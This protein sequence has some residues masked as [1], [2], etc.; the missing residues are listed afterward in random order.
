MHRNICIAFV[1]LYSGFWIFETYFCR[2]SFSDRY[3]V[4]LQRGALPISTHGVR[5][6]SRSRRNFARIPVFSATGRLHEPAHGPGKLLL[7]RRRREG[8]VRHDR[9]R[10]VRHLVLSVRRTHRLVLAAFLARQSDLSQQSNRSQSGCRQTL[11]LLRRSADD[12]NNAFGQ[13]SDPD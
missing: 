4:V 7:L 9:R 8:A 12:R 3:F 13:G 5:P 10:N 6:R 1:V 2:H 11:V